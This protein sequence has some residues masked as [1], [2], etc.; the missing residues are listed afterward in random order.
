MQRFLSGEESGAD[1]DAGPSAT[2]LPV[3][4]R[5]ESP[6]L[7]PYAFLLSVD[8]AGEFLVVWKESLVLGHLQSDADLPFLA[9]VARHHALLERH[10]SLRDGPAWILSPIEDEHVRVDGQLLTAP[11]TLASG[12]LVELGANLVLRYRLP[13]PA[14]E[15]ATL[16]LLAGAECFGATTVLLFAEGPGG[17]L[18]IGPRKECH[19]RTSGLELELVLVRD[20]GRL[21]LAS[22]NLL[23]GRQ[24]DERGLALPCP[25]TR[26]FE[27]SLPRGSPE[28][29][30]PENEA[31]FGIGVG[32]VELHTWRGPPER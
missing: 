5:T 22:E 26:R 30:G 23:V 1:R 2:E 14:S 12:E 13:D 18:V 7:L 16:D 25:P 32:P 10:L 27:L 3:E 31:P 20:G 29:R 9:D 17:R 8:D 21:C 28:S 19:V 6:V 24:K 11:K 15:S 4:S